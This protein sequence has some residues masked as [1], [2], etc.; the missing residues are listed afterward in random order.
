LIDSH[1]HIQS[2]DEVRYPHRPLPGEAAPGAG[3]QPISADELLEAMT[4]SGI[5]RAV[6]VQRARVY[7]Y[8]NSYVL[9][10]ARQHPGV[11]APVVCLDSLSPSAVEDLDHVMAGGAKGLRLTVPSGGPGGGE[12]GVDWFAGRAVLP[13]WQLAADLDVS[14]CL[15]FFRWNR[16]EGLEALGSMARR[17]P[18][19][20]VVV[21]HVGNTDLGG[22]LTELDPIVNCANVTVKVSTL[23]VERLRADGVA[24][25]AAVR[26]LV[27]RLGHDRVM[28]GSDIGQTPGRYPERRAARPAAAA[29]LDSSAVA[30]FVTGVAE[31][32]YF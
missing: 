22:D 32:L 14:I 1:A 13:L 6:L 11:L 30:A 16:D 18:G 27:D 9:D 3:R 12:P 23:N 2:P 17:Y 24:V 29:E 5:K 31:R 15:H 20:Q 26:H 19:A 4:A 28:W 8:D 10:T 7:G 21:D 25:G